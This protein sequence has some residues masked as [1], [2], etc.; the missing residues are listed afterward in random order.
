VLPSLRRYAATNFAVSTISYILSEPYWYSG[1]WFMPCVMMNSGDFA[2]SSF[3]VNTIMFLRCP[4][5]LM[6]IESFT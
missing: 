4:F 1:F 3:G 5:T 2:G 6:N